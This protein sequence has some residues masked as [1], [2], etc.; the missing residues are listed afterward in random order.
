MAVGEIDL[1]VAALLGDAGADMDVVGA[2]AIVVE[3]RLALV[4]AILPA[5]ND[6][7]HQ[8][9]G[10]VENG[11]DRR[12]RRRRAELGEQLSEPALADARRADHGRE[13]AAEVAGMAHIE[14]D[15]LVDVLA[16]LALLV[17]LQRRNADAFLV[18]LG[19]AGVVG[20][21][22]GA[23]DVALVRAVDRPEGKTVV[24]EDRDEGREVRQMIAAPVGVVEQVDVT[25]ADRAFE[26]LMHRL[27]RKRQSAD[28]DRHMLRLRDQATLGIAQR[29]REIAAG[30]QDLRVG[31]AQHGLAHLLDDGAKS[32]LDHGDGDRINGKAHAETRPGRGRAAVRHSEGHQECI[33]PLVSVNTRGDLAADD[34]ASNSR[35]TAM[36]PYA[37]GLQIEPLLCRR[38][39]AGWK[40]SAAPP[41]NGAPRSAAVQ[42]RRSCCRTDRAGRRDRACQLHP[43]ANLADPRCSCHRWRRR[44]RGRP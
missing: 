16:P 38:K 30:V 34:L 43:R 8:A 24:V 29:G 41:A 10:T 22:R 39:R 5:G 3:K 19:G 15:H 42:A 21:V 17:E 33:A 1:E 13:I 25:G 23:A 4:D 31:R 44:H 12:M 9:L 20:A 36:L 27:G 18:D 11:R 35:R 6:R 32:M 28:V 40:V 14:H 2:V 26:K 7:P 37:S